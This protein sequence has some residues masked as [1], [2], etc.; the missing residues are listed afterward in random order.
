MAVKANQPRGATTFLRKPM[1]QKPRTGMSNLQQQIGSP[2]PAVAQP[3][4]PLAPVGAATPT[5]GNVN[6]STGYL[7]TDTG[8]TT[9]Q[10]QIG[11]LND[12]QRKFLM[13]MVRGPMLS[14]QY[15][16]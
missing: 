6:P 8:L 7:Q 1:Q 11:E 13:N 4:A 15:Q 14:P 12:A 3:V 16:A 5:I 10:A 9:L 2:L